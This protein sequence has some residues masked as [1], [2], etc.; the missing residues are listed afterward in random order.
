[1][2]LCDVQRGRN[3]A[4]IGSAVVD[5]SNAQAQCATGLVR[6]GKREGASEPEHA[7]DSID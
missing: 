3:D 4:P 2:G 1:M 7:V 6:S 5:I